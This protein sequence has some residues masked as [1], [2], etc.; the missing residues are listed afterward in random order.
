VALPPALLLPTAGPAPRILLVDDNAINQKVA[1]RLLDKLG[2]EVEIASDGY[3]AIARAT[4]LDAKYQL[5]LMDIQMPGLDGIAATSEIKARLGDQ[6]PPI[7]AMT[8]YS[9][10]D[11]ATRFVQ[12]GLD[13]YL[14]KPVKHQQLSDMLARWLPEPPPA[15]AATNVIAATPA[16]V[17]LDTEVL[18]QLRQLGGHEFTA[19]L[20]SDFE[21]EAGEL[22]NQ[23]A[24]CLSAANWE[25]LHPL[26]HQLKGTSATLGLVALAGQAL[27]IEQL[28]KSSTT[29]ALPIE[30]KLLQH[31]FAQFKAVYP[32]VVS[33][34]ESL[35]AAAESLP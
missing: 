19:D 9:M 5:I 13:D 24:A 33:A 23:A 25:G 26:M 4:A 28:L 6:C 35:P 27:R 10:P 34:P 7:I 15:P 29:T 21:Q 31:Y 17:T 30:F 18:N 8:A 16:P 20:Y 1:A 14:A 12:A 22:L 32:G 3:E 2:C 11:D